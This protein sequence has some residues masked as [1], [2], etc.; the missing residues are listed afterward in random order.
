MEHPFVRAFGVVARLSAV[1]LVLL[2]LLMALAPRYDWAWQAR[3]FLTAAVYRPVKFP[4]FAKDRDPRCSLADAWREAVP[5]TALAA[6]IIE[7]KM[8]VIQTEGGLEQVATPAGNFWIPAGDRQ[9]LA[10]ELAEQV[11]DEYG[12]DTRGVRA[13]D[14]VLDCGASAGTFTRAALRRGAKLVVAIE[15]APW[16]LEC[17]RR[18][19][20]EEIQS[21]RV[22][23]YPKGV[24]D[25]DDTLQINIP[26]GMAT[27]AATVSLPLPG[28]SPRQS[29]SPPSTSWPP[30]C[31]ST[32]S[33]SSKW[34][35][36]A[37]NRT[38][39]AAPFAPSVSFARAWRFRSN[40]ARQIPPPFP[41]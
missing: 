35:S 36:K 26:A 25:Q 31:T 17:L 28:E 21:G 30:T 34:T 19:L 12:G 9:A 40:T 23:L 7:R 10:E 2:A 6:R 15:P 33:I 13:N 4:L 38:R 8:H 22:I 20:R 18:N 37:P 1:G 41:L 29:L 24:W 14:V 5:E 39:S 11:D 3:A 16:A 27:T 32:A